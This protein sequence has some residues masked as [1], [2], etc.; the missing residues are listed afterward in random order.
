MS[1]LDLS[2]CVVLYRSNEVTRRFHRELLVSLAGHDGWQ[3]SYYDNSPD[4]DLRS[5]LNGQERDPRLTY[6]HDSRNLGFSYANNQ[7][8]LPK[9]HW[10]LTRGK[11]PRH[12][13]A[14]WGFL[15]ER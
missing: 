9:E 3:L 4:N 8:I 15:G 11:R 12:D 6:T 10:R 13:D 7:L 2:I 5:L 1:R 14:Y